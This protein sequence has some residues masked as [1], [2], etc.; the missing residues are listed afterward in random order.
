MT[1]NRAT[2][3]KEYLI[4][5]GVLKDKC[6]VKYAYDKKIEKYMG[7]PIRD[8]EVCHRGF[9][10]YWFLEVRKRLRKFGGAAA[11]VYIEDDC[12]LERHIDD[13]IDVLQ[14][15]SKPLVWLGYDHKP[16]L[17]GKNQIGSTM[18]G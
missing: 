17:H 14:A 13:V 4:S 9:V 18:I 8:E 16:S 7:W 2:S 11:V 10:H 3:T 12:R 5:I 15:S 6:Y 1:K